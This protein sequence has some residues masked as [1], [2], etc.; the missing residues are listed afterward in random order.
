MNFIKSFFKPE[1]GWEGDSGF[2][3][4]FDKSSFI[5][6]LVEGR[7]VLDCG[8][9]GDRDEDLLVHELIRSK[10]GSCVGVDVNEGKIRGL[11][12]R[13][14]DV[15]CQDVEKLDL[16]KK[17]DV[18]F[19]GELLEHLNDSGLFLEKAREHLKKD[20]RILLTTPNPYYLTMIFRNLLGI[21]VLVNP[22]HTCWFTPE[23][24]KTLLEKAGFTVEQTLYCQ[25]KSR[26]W[27]NWL[28]GFR[29]NL[30]R[31]IIAVAKR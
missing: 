25:H 29:K 2:R 22:E 7:D 3:L 28:V 26:W 12:A 4:I 24:L 5:S 9:V 8:C 11:K 17:F 19:A 1:G 23:T 30:A 16:K 21:R 6:E 27:I 10:A 13:G 20:G 18:V 15:L 14:F 31:T